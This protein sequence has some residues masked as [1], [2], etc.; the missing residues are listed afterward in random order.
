MATRVEDVAVEGTGDYVA[1]ASPSHQDK[2]RLEVAFDKV[3]NVQDSESKQQ[4]SADGKLVSMSELFQFADAT[5]RL[6]MAVGTGAALLAGTS[7]PI[8]IVLFGDAINSFNPSAGAPTDPHEFRAQINKVSRNFALVGAAVVICCFL[9]VACWSLTA[10]RQAKRIRSA[11]V[12]AIMNKEIGWF[13]VNDPMQLSTR[14]ADSSV[15]IQEGM[16]RKVGDGLNFGSMAISGIVIAL[17][18]GWK[19]A[20]ILMA[21]IPF[22]AFTAFLAMKVLS[23]ATQAG[24][25]SYGKAGAIAQE[26]LSNIRTVHMFNSISHFVKKYEDAL[27]LSTQAGIKK[28]FAVGWGTGLMFFTVFCTYACGMF[29]G[30]LFVANDRRDECTHDCYNGGRVLTVFFSMIMGAMALGQ[31]GPSVQ[32]MFSAR[33]AAYDVFAVINRK[34]LI[35]PLSDDGKK[36]DNVSGRITIENVSFAYPSR[37]EIKVCSNYSLTIE[38]GETVALVGPSGSGKSTVVSL[39]E[40]FYDPLDGL[41]KLDGVDVRE[42]NVRW[43]REQVGLVGQEPALFATSIMENIRHGC[44]GATDEQV[45]EAAKMANAYTFITEFPDGFQT[46]V[47]ERGAQL[48]GGQK[49]RIAIARAIIKNPPVLLLDEATSALDTES[50]R[51]VQESL[52]KL[53]AASRRTTIIVAHRLSTIRNA[54]KIAVH[55]GGRIV[56]L[57]THDELMAIEGG[58]YRLLVEAQNRKKDDDMD[59]MTEMQPHRLKSESF[60]S[61]RTNSYRLIER[62]GSKVSVKD[63]D[64]QTENSDVTDGKAPQVSISRIWKMSLPEW[65]FLA[66]GALGA[67]VNAAVFPVWGVLLTKITVLFFQ[68]KPRDE[69]LTDA[70]YWSLGFVGLGIVFGASI[71]LQHYGFGVTAQRLISRIRLKTFT[72]MLHQEV[73][74]FDLE[75]NSSGALVSRLATDSATLQAMTSDTLNQGLVNL[76]SLAIGFG[77]A[78]YYSWQMTLLLLATSP[79]MGFS[80]YIQA[81]MMSGT[82][83]NKKTNDADTAAGAMLSEAISSIRTVASFS[84]EKALNVAYVAFLDASKAADTKAGIVGGA[85]FGASQGMMF[86]NVA[87]LFYMGGKWVSEGTITFEGMF[88]VIMVIMLSMFAVGMAAQ[89]ATD[90]TKAK[91][92]AARVFSVID[93]KPEIDSTSGT[94]EQLT[95]INGDIEFKNVVFTYPSRPDAQIYTNYNLK[96]KSGQT[97]ALVGASGSGKS[98]AISLLERFYDPAAG[99]VTLD[100]ADLRKLRLPWLREHISLVSQEPVLFAGTIAENIAMGKPGA[101]RDDVIEAAKKA[102]AYDFISNF[103][104]GFDT[105]VGDRGAQV[106]GGQK[107]R[108]AIARAILRDPE[109]LLLDE[110]TSALDNESER[111]VQESL[112]RLLSL[113]K[114]TTIIVAHRLST[115]RNADLI[116]VTKDGAIVEQGTHDQLMALSNGVYKGLVA[117]QMGAH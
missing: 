36:L 32:A 71:T 21:F 70:R 41:V 111:V 113:K 58:H 67:I 106:S 68:L 88:M 1:V 103:P 86:F 39:L 78:F 24:I 63:H 28:G 34:S 38:A 57:G 82:I 26:S 37:P 27:T 14:V 101:T 77:I 81:Q 76:T 15:T 44:P 108:I 50:E 105:D 112:D 2:N 62:S 96:I 31:A 10:S 79:I 54:N 5:D 75:E 49:Q 19:L 18:K 51:V 90:Q 99:T 97:V 84:M 53:L 9:Q 4:L 6:L 40:R 20:L 85:A 35:D 48:S 23:R 8:Q 107:Q 43:L 117:R 98:T 64:E 13:D 89:S 33:A 94:G 59:E 95:H 92:A 16:G 11:Y 30:A 7:Q 22:I 65:K 102:N 91:K 74:W 29:F 100:G 61:S 56:E 73:G 12:S 104:N 46:E 116:A 47:G 110:A 115:I 25:E 80:S 72:A 66:T 42:L 17:I 109:V 55:S 69:L 93:R 87:F 83:N 45:I 114:R 60:S 52:D 3:D